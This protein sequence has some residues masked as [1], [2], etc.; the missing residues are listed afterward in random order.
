MDKYKAYTKENKLKSFIKFNSLSGSKLNL[1]QYNPNKAKELEISLHEQ[2]KF[3]IYAIL[4]NKGFQ[5]L[6]E[7]E[8]K[9]NLGRPDIIYWN[10]DLSQVGIIEVVSSESEESIKKKTV[11]YPIDFELSFIYVNKPLEIQLT[12]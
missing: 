10:E 9:N 12:I 11:N 3:K 4:R 8:F 5:T 6:I 2:F 7:P 1:F